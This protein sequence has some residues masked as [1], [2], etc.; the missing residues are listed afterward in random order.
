M[1]LVL[2][3]ILFIVIVIDI[4]MVKMIVEYFIL[5]MATFLMILIA[6]F[7]LVLFNSYYVRLSSFLV[8]QTFLQ[9]L[10]LLVLFLI[11]LS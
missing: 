9:T 2:G 4:R 10:I 6:L 5:S 8:Y 1:I 7:S 11:L 3:M